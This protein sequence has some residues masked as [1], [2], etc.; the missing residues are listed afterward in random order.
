MG[1]FDCM[2]KYSNN[3][4]EALGAT[5]CLVIALLGCLLLGV[6]DYTIGPELSFSVFYTAP[7]ML[8][9]WYGGKR[10]GFVV[11]VVSAAIWLCADLAAGSDY[12]SWWVPVWNTLV[13]L[14]FFAI[15][16]WLLLL[17]REKLQHEES[18]ADTDP[19]TGLAN[20]R[21][22]QEQLDREH[23][24]VQ[25]YPEPLTIAYFD[26]DNFKH[27]NDTMGHDAGDALLQVV[28]STL[29]SS[30]RVSDFAARLGGDEFALLFPVVEKDAAIAVLQKLQ[31]ELLVAMRDKAWPV[32]FS[33]GAVTFYE[34]MGSSRDMVKK[35]D[36]LMYE[37]KKSGKNN[38][39]HLVWPDDSVTG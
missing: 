20:R 22:F 25:R 24:R 23:V 36:E 31:S 6:F 34:V 17:V 12:T 1:V 7:I 32:T 4:F 29:L 35:V 28:A 37:V 10:Q 16:L 30:I 26:L 21:F 38:I 18:L 13:R 27:V 8:A 3:Y 14:A 33:I 39:H 11:A 19:L 5:R 9:G 2:L 15:I